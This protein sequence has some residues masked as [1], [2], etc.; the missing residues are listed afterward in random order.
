ML[1]SLAEVCFVKS[2]CVDLVQAQLSVCQRAKHQ[3][4]GAVRGVL[5]R[6]AGFGAGENLAL[7]FRAGNCGELWSSRN[8]VCLIGW[9]C[10]CGSNGCVGLILV[11]CAVTWCGYLCLCCGCAWCKSR[12]R[13]VVDFGAKITPLTPCMHAAAI[14]HL[15]HMHYTR[16]S[17]STG[18]TDPWGDAGCCRSKTKLASK[19]AP[20][21]LHLSL[22]PFF[23]SM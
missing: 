6:A 2:C 14:F 22:C 8:L 23:S 9:R 17:M 21:D 5:A 13:L 16:W 12:F 7:V 18:R 11:G 1:E 20:V 19:S 15:T 10:R 3:A 4:G